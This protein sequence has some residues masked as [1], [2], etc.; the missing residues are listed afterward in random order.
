MD[1][2]FGSY[3]GRPID[4][5]TTYH[6]TA[7]QVWS[8]FGDDTDV[9]DGCLLSFVRRANEVGS[10]NARGG[11]DGLGTLRLLPSMLPILTS[12][13][14]R[15]ATEAARALAKWSLRY[16]E[17]SESLTQDPATLRALE[18]NLV[19]KSTTSEAW[20]L[21][22][23]HADLVAA[24]SSSNL[25]PLIP[26]LIT[27]VDSDADTAT[28]VS[29]RTAAARALTTLAGSTSHQATD[30]L[31]ALVRSLRWH[32][33]RSAQSPPAA[34]FAY[35]CAACL[36]T[37]V[38]VCPN[39]E[40]AA[41][42][43]TPD[44]IA[45]LEANMEARTLSEA[46][47]SIACLAKN[48]NLLQ[49]ALIAHGAVLA[50]TRI[51]HAHIP[52]G[53]QPTGDA[54]FTDRDAV[55][56]AAAGALANLCFGGDEH[57]T[58]GQ[59]AITSCDGIRVIAEALHEWVRLIRDTAHGRHVTGPAVAPLRTIILTLANATRHNSINQ[60]RAANC[61]ALKA[62]ID[63]VDCHR[64]I[65]PE[66]CGDTVERALGCLLNLVDGSPDLASKVRDARG[67]LV[68]QAIIPTLQKDSAAATY[69]AKLLAAVVS[70]NVEKKSQPPP[71]PTVTPAPK[72]LA[73]DPSSTSCVEAAKLAALLPPPPA[74]APMAPSRPSSSMMA[75][76]ATAQANMALHSPF[77][78]TAL[79]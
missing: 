60:H 41:L 62:L 61:G 45:F 29:A 10:G 1:R 73:F 63:V 56:T 8:E 58:P 71:P 28:A 12:G 2:R 57:S 48:H 79:W 43:L 21:V 51:L 14:P 31:P 44:L 76:T 33:K 5:Y 50:T 75:S 65:P 40:T 18:T 66:F 36:R 26:A 9:V 78:R 13:S 35:A 4:D 11:A 53:C 7:S 20:D 34:D 52:R 55:F 30:A 25:K 68:I 70:R 16:P 67:D 15:V 24:C 17:V 46:L 3:V 22:A 59:S 64:K 77:R 54:V 42:L 38:Q 72:K 47:Q 27:I 23:A 69:V 19:R 37:I 49:P 39:V 74:A 6:Q 32:A